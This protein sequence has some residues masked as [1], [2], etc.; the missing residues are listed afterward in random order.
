MQAFKDA[1]GS[2]RLCWT[3]LSLHLEGAPKQRDARPFAYAYV[4][5]QDEAHA[6]HMFRERWVKHEGKWFT[7]VVGLVPNKSES[8][9][10]G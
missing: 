6:F 9:K 1:Y 7:R 3:R 5:W 4:L 8:E 2:I 10:V